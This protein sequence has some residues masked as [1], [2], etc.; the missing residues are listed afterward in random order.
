MGIAALRGVNACS[1]FFQTAERVK[2]N[3]CIFNAGTTELRCVPKY[4]S[5]CTYVDD[6]NRITVTRRI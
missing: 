5:Y 4:T 2:R 1:S 6:F 3:A